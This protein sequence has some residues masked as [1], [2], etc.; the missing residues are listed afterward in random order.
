MGLGFMRGFGGGFWRG[1]D[2]GRSKALAAIVDELKLSVCFIR[3]L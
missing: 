2:L 1:S 3:C